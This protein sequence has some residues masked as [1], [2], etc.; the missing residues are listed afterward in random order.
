VL[1][2]RIGFGCK[3]TTLGRMLNEMGIRWK[4]CG[5]RIKITER[6]NT[7]NGKCA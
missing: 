2:G 7:V 5:S 1:K 3:V 4:M 6:E